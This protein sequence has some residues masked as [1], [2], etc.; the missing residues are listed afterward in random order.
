MLNR[1]K[2]TVSTTEW[3]AQQSHNNSDTGNDNNT[4][5]VELFIVNFF[6]IADLKKEY[7]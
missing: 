2:L 4:N 6:F 3:W 5:I 1:V 7:K